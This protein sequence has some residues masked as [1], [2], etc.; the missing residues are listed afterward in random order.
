MMKSKQFPRAFKDIPEIGDQFVNFLLAYGETPALDIEDNFDIWIKAPLTKKQQRL[1]DAFIRRWTKVIQVNAHIKCTFLT[2]ESDGH[3]YFHLS[4]WT[5][6]P[7]RKVNWKIW[8]K[9]DSL[10]RNM[11]R[12]IIEDGMEL[13]ESINGPIMNSKIQID[14]SLTSTVTALSVRP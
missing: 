12:D 9:M 8:D 4:F 2:D 13:E 10:V 6:N 11:Y 7:D 1:M 3:R 14:Y 5:G